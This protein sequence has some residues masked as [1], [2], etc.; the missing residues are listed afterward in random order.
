[1]SFVQTRKSKFRDYNGEVIRYFDLDSYDRNEHDSYGNITEF[2]NLQIVTG[3]DI[4]E[5]DILVSPE[6]FYFL[7]V[8]EDGCFFAKD[9]K[10]KYYLYKCLHMDIAG[11]VYENSDLLQKS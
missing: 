1:M 10:G 7:V 2:T 3:K 6:G 9:S 5:G 4:Y 8:F 11:T